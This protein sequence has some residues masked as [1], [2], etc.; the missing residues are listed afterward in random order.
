MF[1]RT[2]FPLSSV[3]LTPALEPERFVLKG[4]VADFR[5]AMRFVRGVE[6]ADGVQ[7]LGDAAFLGMLEA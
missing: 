4:P 3:Y 5:P 6:E 7:V 1:L 2:E